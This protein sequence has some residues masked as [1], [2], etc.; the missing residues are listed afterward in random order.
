MYR[1]ALTTAL[2]RALADSPVV[3]L[4]GARQTGKSTLVRALAEGDHPATYVTLDDLA[5]LG[6][7]R[8]DPAGFLAGLPRPLILDEVQRC[9]DLFLAIKAE[10]DEQRTPGRFLLTGSA[11]VEVV[12]TLA[13]ALVGRVELLTLR[14]LSRGEVLG[15]REGF[16]DAAFADG[17]PDLGADEDGADV[18][19]L[20]A[21]GGYP[22]PLTRDAPER[23]DAW[24]R[25]YVETLLQRDVREL[26]AI[27]GLLALPDLLRLL[28]TRLGGLLNVAD[29]ARASDLKHTTLKRYMALLEGT[30]LIQRLPAWS[31]NLGKRLVKA[32]KLFVHD[33]GLAWHLL[34]GMGVPPASDQ[35]LRGALL[36]AFVLTELQKQIE[37]SALRPRVYHHRT[38]GGEEVD[39]LLEAPDGRCVGV[40]VK[41]TASPG[42]A[43][44]N[45]LRRL[46]DQLGERF[47]RGVVL[48]TGPGVVPAGE[49]LHALPVSAL[50]RWGARPMEGA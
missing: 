11:S 35:P 12:P 8:A 13:D 47:V 18:W 10:V 6:A 28:A 1:R 37:V 33:T 29:V 17:L 22:E 15:V 39:L 34:G 31:A 25:G 46:A 44:F 32:P 26:S 2:G 43:A 9:P 7:C 14:P 27:E 49:R 50:W 38:H 20:V 5:V 42:P 45:G 19:E 16:V 23:R 30:F 24:Y 21:G 3:F 36:E 4:G 41:A 40:E 48:H